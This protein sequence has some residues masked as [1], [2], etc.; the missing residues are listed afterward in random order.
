MSG[1]PLLLTLDHKHLF[2]DL[3]KLHPHLLTI[4]NLEG[5]ALLEVSIIFTTNETVRKLNVEYLGHDYDT[6][7]ISFSLED[8]PATRALDGE[9]Y[10]NLDMAVSRHAEFNATFQEE[11]YRYA[12]HGLLHLMHY[13]DKT[14]QEL[15]VMKARE[16]HYLHMITKS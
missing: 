7:V 15:E 1:S 6:D 12:I 5:Y 8:A 4:C 14:P 9:I 2:I 11:A 3:D 10:V 13:D 16:S